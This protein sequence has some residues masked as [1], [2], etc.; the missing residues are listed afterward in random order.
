MS[1]DK[2]TFL[3]SDVTFLVH[4]PSGAA[5]PVLKH[6]DV[7]ESVDDAFDAVILLEG[8]GIDD[9]CGELAVRHRL[10]VPMINATGDSGIRGIQ[11]NLPDD[12]IAV[13]QIASATAE[14]RRRLGGLPGP[15]NPADAAGLQVLALAY[16]EDVDITA[17]WA[18]DRSEMVRYPLLQG[19]AGARD[20][21]ELLAGADLLSRTPFDTLHQC[22]DCGSSRLNVREECPACRSSNIVEEENVHHYRCAHIGP[23]STFEK[24]RTLICP[25]CSTE[26]RHY[27][28]DYD[29]PGATRHCHDCGHTSDEPEVGFVCTDCGA[30]TA[31]EAIGRRAWYHYALT[32]AGIN[33]VTVGVLPTRSLADTFSRVMGTYSPRDVSL[34]LE[35]MTSAANRYERPLSTFR[36]E[37]ENRADL[38]ASNSGAEVERIFALIAKLISEALRTC[39]MVA[40]KNDILYI[41][42]P[43]TEEDAATFAFQRIRDTIAETIEDKVELNIQGYSGE[44][45]A[46][47]LEKLQR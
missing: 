25:K 37:I 38:E 30:H 18:G 46:D 45:I 1:E 32:T 43:E 27:G 34:V 44:A 20:I 4:H 35:I 15:L 17:V 29:R 33:A 7:T 21:L 19:V 14:L 11:M 16:A 8:V 6:L 28:V 41:M 3:K 10:V 39:D 5:H 47:F 42:L 36:L 12:A 13:E 23:E 40:V 31:G 22:G 2:L 9:L 26:L 24:E